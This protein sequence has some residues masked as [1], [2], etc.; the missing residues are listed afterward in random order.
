MTKCL[1]GF[2]KNCAR[3]KKV[4]KNT[5]MVIETKCKK[6]I[7]GGYCEQDDDKWENKT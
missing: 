7:C 4:C 3:P 6:N 5:M 2:L 1:H